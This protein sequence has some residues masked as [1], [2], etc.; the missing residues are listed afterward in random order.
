[1]IRQ[2][3]S[4]FLIDES[5]NETLEL[6]NILSKICIDKNERNFI[7]ESIDKLYGKNARIEG[8]AYFEKDS[9]YSF[10]E[11]TG[12]SVEDMFG[13]KRRIDFYLHKSFVF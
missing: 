3:V 13:K 7:I 5:Q 8:V 1:M 9:P 10:D 2:N 11:I 6:F 4:S 12:N